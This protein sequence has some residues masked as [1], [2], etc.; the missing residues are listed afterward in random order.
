[1]KRPAKEHFVQGMRF[2]LANDAQMTPPVACELSVGDLVTYTNEFG[3]RFPNRTVTGFAPT[4]EYGRFV[5]FDNS[6]WW[7]P[8]SPRFFTKQTH[9]ES[10]D[11]SIGY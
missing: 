9:L 10:M 3:A 7:F 1:M 6:A 8:D 4:V 2:P 5:Y 11:A